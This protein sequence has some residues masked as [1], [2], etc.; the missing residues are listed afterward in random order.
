MERDKV[1]DIVLGMPRNMDGS[2]G[3]AAEKIARVC[4]EA[5]RAAIPGCTVKLWDERLTSVAAQ[6]ALHEAGRNVKQSRAVIDQVAVSAGWNTPVENAVAVVAMP[7]D[8]D[9]YEAPTLAQMVLAEA[10]LA[11]GEVSAA[12]G[13]AREAAAIAATG[14]W[15]LLNADAQLLLARALSACGDHE[16]AAEAARAGLAG[17]R[18]S[19]SRP[20]P[21]GLSR[22]SNHWRS[23]VANRHS[24]PRT[25]HL[26]GVGRIWSTSSC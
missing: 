25:V 7:T 16:H 26:L 6:R 14:D 3:P 5:S 2:Y 12:V 22:S 21:R 15:T 1:S 4:R 11:T 10:R 17:Y 20:A 18:P 24:R 19:S 13:S 9:P 8:D 23:R